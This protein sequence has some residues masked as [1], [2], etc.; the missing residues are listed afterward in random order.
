MKQDLELNEEI[1]DYVR[2]GGK[3]GSLK[4]RKI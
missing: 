2:K 3:D 1:R 4:F